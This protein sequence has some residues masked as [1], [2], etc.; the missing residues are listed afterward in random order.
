MA[1]KKTYTPDLREYYQMSKPK[2]SA[3]KLGYVLSQLEG[4]ERANLDAAL[5]DPMV[6]AT[7]IVDVIAKKVP[8]FELT[9][10]AITSHKR[11]TCTCATQDQT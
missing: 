3:C 8:G 1:T 2:K 5:R 4:Q 11:G 6:T 9:V 7:G 10:P